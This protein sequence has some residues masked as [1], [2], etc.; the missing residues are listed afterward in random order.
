MLAKRSPIILLSITLP[1]VIATAISL[2]AAAAMSLEFALIHFVSAAVVVFAAGKLEYWK[3]AILSVGTATLVMMA[4][5]YWISIIMPDVYDNF[6]TYLYVMALGGM[7]LLL[8]ERTGK[9]EREKPAK[10]RLAGALR[11]FLRHTAVFALMMFAV[12]LPREYFG[13]GTI[14]GAPVP[15]VFRLPGVLIPFFGFIYVGFFLAVL[16]SISKRLTYMAVLADRRREAREKTRYT[17]I[18]V[19]L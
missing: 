7:A 6:R 18:R 11:D 14:W 5:R 13:S 12:A 15:I 19:D 10:D 9:N 1:F 3:R 16:R 8:E 2:R 17:R 4:A